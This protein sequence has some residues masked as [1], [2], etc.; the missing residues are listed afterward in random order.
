MME[1]SVIDWRRS[2]SKLQTTWS[3]IILTVTN[4]P[5][6]QSETS[7]LKTVLFGDATLW[8]LNYALLIMMMMMALFCFPT[9][10]KTKPKQQPEHN[11]K[12]ELV[13]SQTHSGHGGGGRSGWQVDRCKHVGAYDTVARTLDL[14][15]HRVAT[16]LLRQ[17]HHQAIDSSTK[18]GPE[19]RRCIVVDDGIGTWVAVWHA[20]P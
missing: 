6:R 12:S 17:A 1:F 19:V 14:G 8:L 15:K 4:V 18:A 16:W 5:V 9:Q 10:C 7:T 20:V 2:H 11:G 3:T 13:T